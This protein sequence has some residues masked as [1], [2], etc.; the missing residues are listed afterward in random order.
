MKQKKKEAINKAEIIKKNKEVGQCKYEFETQEDDAENILII[1][2]TDS[3]KPAL[4]NII[5]NTSVFAEGDFMVVCR[6]Y[7]TCRDFVQTLASIAHQPI[8]TGE[9]SNNIIGIFASCQGN[10]KMECWDNICGKINVSM[11]TRGRW[12]ESKYSFRKI[13]RTQDREVEIEVEINIPFVAYAE[14]QQNFIIV[15]Q[16]I[17]KVIY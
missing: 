3:G 6:D 14:V 1:G 9:F 12:K 7:M 16:L 8:N 2:R 4:A 5:I 17:K 11:N 10:Y 13:K 15:A